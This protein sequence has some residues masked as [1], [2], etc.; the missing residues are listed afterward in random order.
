MLSSKPLS[1]IVKLSCDISNYFN[2][3]YIYI[4]IYI[5]VKQEHNNIP[6]C[7]NTAGCNPLHNLKNP[8]SLTVNYNKDNKLQLYKQCNCIKSRNTI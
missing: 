6:I 7:L 1:I 8:S 3:T 2:K 4:Y 5:F